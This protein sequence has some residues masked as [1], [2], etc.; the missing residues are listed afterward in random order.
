[1]TGTT[2]TARDGSGNW[3]LE[4]LRTATDGWKLGRVLT[5]P[6]SMAQWVGSQLEFPPHELTG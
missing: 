3:E 6:A 2:F 4:L 1:M 5:A